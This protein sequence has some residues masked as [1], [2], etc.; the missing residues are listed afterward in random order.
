MFRVIGATFG[1]HK[2]GIS[3]DKNHFYFTLDSFKTQH[4]TKC[5]FS[6]SLFYVL[7]NSKCSCESFIPSTFPN[8]THVILKREKGI[9]QQFFYGSSFLQINSCVVQCVKINA[10]LQRFTFDLHHFQHCRLSNRHNLSKLL[11]Y[12]IGM[13]GGSK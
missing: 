1:A 9:V 13:G 10:P 12:F 4:A 11:Q 6:S 7:C 2:W 8:K 5:V 3:V